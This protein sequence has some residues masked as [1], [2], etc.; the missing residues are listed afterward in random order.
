MTLGA[1]DWIGF[2]VVET[3]FWNASSSQDHQPNLT[4]GAL[5]GDV[6]DASGDFGYTLVV[7]IELEARSA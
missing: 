1:E 5:I 6:C 3:I 2:S 4:L 7:H